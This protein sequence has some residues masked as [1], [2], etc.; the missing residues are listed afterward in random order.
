MPQHAVAA[1]SPAR[2][3]GSLQRRCFDPLHFLSSAGGFTCSL[4]WAFSRRSSPPTA[5]PL[6]NPTPHTPGSSRQSRLKERCRRAPP[7]PWSRLTPRSR[8]GSR[9][10]LCT[11][12]GT[13]TSPLCVGFPS[14]SDR[15]GGFPRCSAPP[16]CRGLPARKLRGRHLP[17][18]CT[19][20]RPHR[21]PLTQTPPPPHPH[22]NKR[23]QVA[24]VQEGELFRVECIDWT[25]GQIKDSDSAEDMKTVDLSVIHWLSGPIRVGGARRVPPHV[26]GVAFVGLKCA[27]PV[28]P[29]AA[30]LGRPPLK[31]NAA[32]LRPT[33]TEH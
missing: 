9:K 7:R 24:E 10:H 30:G 33:P 32:P 25:G 14:P 16:L 13:P 4:G 8:H 6:H 18:S 20:L 29:G 22:V 11:T 2:R 1:L 19:H 28:C 21:P 17:V 5:H 31:S 3:S 26:S 23:P 12:G 15:L 27:G